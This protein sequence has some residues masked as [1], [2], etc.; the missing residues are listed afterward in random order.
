[1]R[2]QVLCSGAGHPAGLPAQG[3]RPPAS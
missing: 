2:I 1:M 3:L